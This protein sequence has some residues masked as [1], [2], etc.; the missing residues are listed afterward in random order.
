MLSLSNYKVNLQL[1][2]SPRMKMFPLREVHLSSLDLC[3]CL[4]AMLTRKSGK[5]VVWSRWVSRVKFFLHRQ[6]ST[7][8]KIFPGIDLAAQEKHWNLI[9]LKHWNWIFCFLTFP[10][11][12]SVLFLGES[13]ST[14][15]SDRRDIVAMQAEAYTYRHDT[16]KA[17]S[18][19][20]FKRK[21][22]VYDGKLKIQLSCQILFL[23]SLE[24]ESILP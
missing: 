10:I 11:S 23:I 4:C 8:S 16:S 14:T 12:L 19:G 7:V 17:S 5:F 21:H 6:T 13:E 2:P 18:D 20:K 15:N 1:F 24:Y 9:R 3:V 22:I